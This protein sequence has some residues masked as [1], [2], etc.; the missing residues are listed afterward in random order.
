MI[1]SDY[2]GS[3]PL[4]NKRLVVEHGHSIIDKAMKHGD[5]PM[6]DDSVTTYGKFCEYFWVSS[7]EGSHLMRS[8]SEA[9]HFP[10]IGKVAWR[11]AEIQQL[12]SETFWNHRFQKL[13]DVLMCIH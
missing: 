12:K 9:V 11:V 13:I 3:Y 7:V 6:L 5:V 2:S 1:N 10:K 8:I 4:V